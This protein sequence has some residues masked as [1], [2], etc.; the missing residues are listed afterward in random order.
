MASDDEH[1]E[2]VGEHKP[3]SVT[4]IRLKNF[5]THGN[6]EFECGPR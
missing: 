2:V 5:L 1:L 4:K 6:V 3:G